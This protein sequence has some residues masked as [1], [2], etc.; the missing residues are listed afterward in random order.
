[1]KTYKISPH[2]VLPLGEVCP[3]EMRQLARGYVDEK[4]MVMVR[5]IRIIKGYGSIFLL[6]AVAL[7]LAILLLVPFGGMI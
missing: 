4:L 1:V 3:I 2:Q 5:Q 6:S 7:I